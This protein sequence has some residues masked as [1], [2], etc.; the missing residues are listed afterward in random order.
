[1]AG[2]YSCRRKTQENLITESLSSLD[3]FGG[4]L[5][6]FEELVQSSHRT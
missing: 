4:I 3:I 5:V 1:M 2:V 6:N